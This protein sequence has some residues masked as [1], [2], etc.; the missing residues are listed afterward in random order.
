MSKSI[1]RELLLKVKRCDW[2]NLNN[3]LSI[4]YHDKE[5]GVP[6]FKDDLHF[7]HIALS[8]FQAGLSWDLILK[9]RKV[10]K[11][12]FNNFNPYAVAGYNS[13]DINKIIN[14]KKAIRNKKKI[15]AVVN[16]AKVFIHIA[17]EFGSFNK[18]IWNFFNNRIQLNNYI[19]WSLIPPQTDKSKS[20]SNELNK[21]GFKFFGPKIAYAYMQSIGI[22]ND[23]ATICFRYKELKKYKPNF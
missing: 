15:Y 10:L 22:V 11:R 7:E 6:S 18:W 9:K 19:S 13:K 2:V 3:P 14:N 4:E 20:L 5:W 21:K 8:C 1:S 16:N 12:L 23:H 17:K